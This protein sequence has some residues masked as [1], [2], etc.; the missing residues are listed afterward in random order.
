MH[1]VLIAYLLPAAVPQASRTAVVA[2]AAA[3]ARS[4]QQAPLVAAGSFAAGIAVGRVTKDANAFY[5]TAADVPNTYLRNGKLFNA[6]VV[7]VTDGDTLRVR[8]CPWPWPIPAPTPAGKASDTTIAVRL[9]AVDAPEIGKFGSVTQPFAEDSKEF[10]VSAVLGRR[11]R[12][13]PLQRDRYGRLV[14]EVRH[15]PLGR[16]D[17]SMS[18]LRRGLAVVYRGGDGT[19]GAGTLQRWERAEER[20]QRKRLGLWR[21]GVEGAVSPSEYKAAQRR[22]S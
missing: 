11:V 4:V 12:V 3:V 6:K 7:S 15:G 1:A 5:P 21:D 16:S 19:Y 9:L 13:L 22:R 18:L 2:A 20:A 10:V 17:L 8:H 14:C